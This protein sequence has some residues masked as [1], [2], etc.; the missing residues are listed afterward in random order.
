[1]LDFIGGIPNNTRRD[2][3]SPVFNLEPERH[4]FKKALVNLSLTQ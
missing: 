3:L 4:R 1:L 2:G